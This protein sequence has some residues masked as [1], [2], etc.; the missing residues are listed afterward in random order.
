LDPLTICIEWLGKELLTDVPHRMITLTVP[1][2]IRPFFLWN[3]K[4]LGFLACRVLP[5]RAL[6]R[7]IGRNSAET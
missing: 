6:R 4:L 1:E 3:R 5:E 2:R 7:K